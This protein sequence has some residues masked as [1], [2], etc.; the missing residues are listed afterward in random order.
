MAASTASARRA[1]TRSPTTRS[2]IPTARTRARWARCSAA[3]PTRPSTAPSRTPRSRSRGGAAYTKD[4]K[5]AL[6]VDFSDDVAGPFPANFLCFQYGGNAGGVCD[7]AKGYIYGYNPACSVPARRRQVDEL[8]LHRRRRL[9][10]Q[11]GARR[12]DVGVRARRRRRDPGQPDETQPERLGGQGQPLRPAVRRH[13]AR[14]H[15][16]G[17]RRSPPRRRSV[18]VGD[19]VSFQAQAT[20]A[21]SGVAAGSTLEL[22]RQHRRAAAARPRPTRSRRPAPTRSA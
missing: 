14:P 4:A 17:R 8:H 11:P 7:A 10:R 6:K 3:A 16:A 19:L 15:R 22:G 9:G 20:D 5:V 2:S 21:T 13:R 12:P 1:A 18:K